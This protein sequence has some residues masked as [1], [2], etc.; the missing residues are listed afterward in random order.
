MAR[1]KRV[2]RNGMFITVVFEEQIQPGTFEFALHHLVDHCVELL[3]HGVHFS[4]KPAAWRSEPFW[5]IATHDC[6]CGRILSAGAD[7][8]AGINRASQETPWDR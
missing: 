2:Q 7:C 8:S 3:S 5:C 6:I 4:R 1:Y